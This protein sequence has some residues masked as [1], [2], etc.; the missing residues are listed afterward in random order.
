MIIDKIKNILEENDYELDSESISRI[1]IMLES[2]RDDN[3]RRNWC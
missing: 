2:I 3:R 1:Q